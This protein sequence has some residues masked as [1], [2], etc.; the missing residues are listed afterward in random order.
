MISN[1]LD[2][3]IMEFVKEVSPSGAYLMGFN[4]YAG[5]LFV[6]SEANIDAALRKV[7]ALRAKAWTALLR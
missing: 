5:K 3:Q 4:G 6:A 2:K 7:R 1:A